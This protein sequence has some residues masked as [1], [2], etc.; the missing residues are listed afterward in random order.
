VRK[1]RRGTADNNDVKEDVRDARASE[2]RPDAAAGPESAGLRLWSFR[3]GRAGSGPPA[4]VRLLREAKGPQ[5]TPVRGSGARAAAPLP[6]RVCR[7]L[8]VRALDAPARGILA[9]PGHRRRALA[10]APA[11]WLAVLTLLAAA[12]LALAGGR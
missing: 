6:G 12:A 1:G 9:G 4:P 2:A 7:L 3:S 10:R 11:V 8:P 5:A